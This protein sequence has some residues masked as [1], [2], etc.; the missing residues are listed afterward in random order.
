MRR[1]SYLA[2]HFSRAVAVWSL[3]S[4]LSVSSGSSADV[5]RRTHPSNSRTTPVRF[6]RSS[7]A[8]P[9]EPAFL[10]YTAYFSRRRGS[11][12]KFAR[13]VGLVGRAMMSNTDSG[14]MGW[15]GMSSSKCHRGIT[16]A[17]DRVFLDTINSRR[18]LIYHQSHV[19]CK[20]LGSAVQPTEGSESSATLAV[21][22]L[23]LTL[24]RWMPGDV[25]RAPAL[26]S[27][28]LSTG[29]STSPCMASV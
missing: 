21:D 22:N 6:R 10:S 8:N 5:A 28:T 26:D 23:I 19:T 12:L 11:K 17:Y 15:A 2:S 27:L 14:V 18:F 24:A 4:S 20:L 25:V 13:L 16:T 3:S 1:L 29:W 9:N 7:G